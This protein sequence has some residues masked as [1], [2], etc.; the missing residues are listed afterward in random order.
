MSPFAQLQDVAMGLMV[1]VLT[2][3]VGA[4]AFCKALDYID[5]WRG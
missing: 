4:I 5:T 2:I 1:A 3:Q